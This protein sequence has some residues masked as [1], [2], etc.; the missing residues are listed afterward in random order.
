MN[1]SLR[2]YIK[3]FFLI[4]LIFRIRIIDDSSILAAN[5]IRIIEAIH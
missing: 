4:P 2:L 3:F 1:I 5:F